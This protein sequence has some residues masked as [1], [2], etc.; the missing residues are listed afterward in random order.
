MYVYQYLSIILAFI[1]I[2]APYL[3]L[4]SKLYTDITRSI[5]GKTFTTRYY[6][7]LIVYLALALG[8][9]VLVLPKIR[10]DTTRNMLYDSL[11]YGG[12]LGIVS[13]AT[14]DFTAHFMFDGWTLG[15]SIMDTIWGATLCSLVSFITVYLWK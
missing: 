6:S 12:V 14:F 10:K 4:N 7:A 5:S 8:V 11:L 15:V 2:D 3:Y 13:Y 1:V 9:F